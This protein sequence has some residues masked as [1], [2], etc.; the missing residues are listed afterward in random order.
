MRILVTGRSGQLAAAIA[1][2]AKDRSEIELTL[3]GRPQLDLEQPDVA[4][5]EIL[6]QRP[7]IVVN[8]AAYTAVDRAE[9]EAQRAFTV[10]SAGAAAAA[11]AAARLDVPF[12]HI[13]TD[14]VFD[15]R[16]PSPYVESD[17]TN[18]LNVYGRTKLAGEKAVLEA[19]PGALILRTSWIFSP[20][21]SNFVKTMLKV[22]S[23]RPILRVVS[24][25]L[26]NPTSALD[27]AAAI[28]EIAPTLQGVP[29]GLFH[30]TGGGSA[31][32][33]SFAA[34][35]FR[36]KSRHGGPTPALQAI[37]SSEYNTAAVRP[38]NSRLNCTAFE[39]RFG[40][41]LRPW[42]EAVAE[43]VESCLSG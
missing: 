28:L 4:C 36:E 42:T 29:G 25:Q 3:L 15:G 20:F 32:W 12:V 41:T 22:G 35:I 37:T 19:H 16:K 39:Q 24:D 1:E 11:R 43:T 7:D 18:P 27:L 38:A 23:E 33:H 30:L 40:V 6:A 8:A 14:Y 17:E 5:R 26:G 31:S 21:G 10:N 9:G 13:S 2:K 34:F